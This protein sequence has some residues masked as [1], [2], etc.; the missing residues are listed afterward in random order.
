MSGSNLGENK[1]EASNSDSNPKELKLSK[2]LQIAVATGA[3]TIF[4]GVLTFMGTVI[5]S[6]YDTFITKPKE[7]N[8]QLML[9]VL[10]K[11]KDL[12][13]LNRVGFLIDAELLEGTVFWDINKPLM[14][15]KAVIYLGNKL[16]W[17]AQYEGAGFQALLDQNLLQANEYFSTSWKY[18]NEYNNVQEINTLINQVKTEDYKKWTEKEWTE[19]MYCPITKYFY[20]G[21]PDGIKKQMNEKVDKYKAECENSVK[22]E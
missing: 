7:R 11:E 2:E 19:K 9:K 18:Y 13:I 6:T 20:W 17:A 12:E 21:M 3:A 16:M 5:V 15:Q 4:V 22:K 8:L 10:E 14:E 1:P